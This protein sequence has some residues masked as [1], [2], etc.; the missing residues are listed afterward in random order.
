MSFSSMFEKPQRPD[1]HDWNS[2]DNYLAVH[3]SALKHWADWFIVANSIIPEMIAGDRLRLSGRLLCQDGLYIDV[4]KTLEVRADGWV[5]TI[6]YSYHVGF[7]GPPMRSLFRYDNAHTYVREGH[8]DAHHRHA[9]DWSTGEEIRS[10]IHVG[11]ENWPHLS[12]VIE[13]VYGWWQQN[14]QL[15]GQ[16][17]DPSANR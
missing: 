5:R 6:R 13:E 16:R 17:H 4:D 1:P 11:Y 15:L 14:T 9:Y 12:D 8:P 2:L 10:P 3:D 7:E